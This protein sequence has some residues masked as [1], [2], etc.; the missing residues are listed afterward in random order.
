GFYYGFRTAAGAFVKLNEDGQA[1]VIT[2]LVDNGQGNDTMAAMVVAEELGLPL[3]D[4]KVVNADTEICPPD[5]GSHSMTTTFVSGRA[6]Q[7]AARDAKGQLLEVV[8]QKL[9][10]RPEDLV[11]RGK[12]IYVKGSPDRS[13]PIR[14][15]VG[16]ALLNRQQILGRA[17][18]A[19]QVDPLDW[20]EGK[21]EGQ[22]T[23]AYTYG[24]VLAEVEVDP[25]SGEIKVV[26]LVGAADCGKAI[27]PD[28][29]EGQIEG[30][31]IFA[32]GQALAEK[33]VWED[34]LLLNPSYL[35]YKITPIG[36]MPQIETI[37]VESHDPQGPFG[38]KQAA[39]ATHIAAV[40]A[41]A[42]AVANAIGARINSLP[43]TP[44]KVLAA[45]KQRG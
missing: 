5:P 34:G 23:G 39:E 43:I 42:N 19:P 33:L 15:A 38:A 18:Y 27:N 6:C 4:V 35:E 16:L 32:L 14:N 45:L 22:M 37:I 13:L 28:A 41:I 36:K 24:C 8:A 11:M 7:L 12:M 21:I 25:D 31:V 17:H 9:E 2:G 1:T 30:G 3:D 40:P 26:K 20:V 29:L 44:E 10:C